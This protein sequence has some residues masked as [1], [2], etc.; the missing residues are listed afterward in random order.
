MLQTCCLYFCKDTSFP[1]RSWSSSSLLLG[2]RHS[3]LTPLVAVSSLTAARKDPLVVLSNE[4][5]WPMLPPSKVP[6]E[7]PL[8]LIFGWHPINAASSSG[9]TCLS[10]FLMCLDSLHWAPFRKRCDVL[11]H[12]GVVRC[13][14]HFC[15][16]L[17][18]DRFLPRQPLCWTSCSL[19]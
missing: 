5:V 11:V 19:N 15:H 16:C 13:S 4:A 3:N 10:V 9:G 12:T 1:G 8:S 7:P 6:T 18:S 14:P 2:A 17:L